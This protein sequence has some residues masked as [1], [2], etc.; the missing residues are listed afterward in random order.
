MNCDRIAP[1]YRWLEYLAFA[2]FPQRCRRQYLNDVRNVHR[3]LLIGEGDGRFLRRLYQSSPDA[4]IDYVDMSEVMA[5]LAQRHGKY[6]A[7]GRSPRFHRLDALNEPLPRLSY[8]LIA[9]HFFLDCFDQDEIPA[10]IRNI[11]T[12]ASDDARWVVSEFQQPRWGIW[13]FIGGLLLPAMYWFFRWTTGL[14]ASSLPEYR[15]AFE[16]NRFF[17]KHERSFMRGLLVA[18]L[19]TRKPTS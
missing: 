2:N 18:Q 12:S 8:D 6:P 13:K 9:T 17:L 1:W 3:A 16:A 10:L 14:K 7:H 11:A 19:W 5:R 15:C 4:A